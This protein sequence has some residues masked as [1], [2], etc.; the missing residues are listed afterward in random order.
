MVAS[1]FPLSHTL[2]TITNNNTSGFSFYHSFERV[3]KSLASTHQNPIGFFVTAKTRAKAFRIS[4]SP[5]HDHPP[6]KLAIWSA[7]L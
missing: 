7:V 3:Y 6:L 2:I 1:A 5:Y 4:F